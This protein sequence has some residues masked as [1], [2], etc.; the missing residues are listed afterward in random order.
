MNE[1]INFFVTLNNVPQINLVPLPTVTVYDAVT[2]S[3]VLT[4]TSTE[5]GG[6]FYKFTMPTLDP[7]INYLIVADA[8]STFPN[9][10][11]YY[12]GEINALNSLAA[13]TIWDY[14]ANNTFTAGSFGEMINNI[15]NTVASTD[16]T[17]GI[18]MALLNTL[19]KYAQNRAKVD[20]NTKTL[21]LYDDDQTTPIKIFKL[22]N[23][24]SVLDINTVFERVPQ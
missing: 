19:L 15:Q 18:S 17:T 11:R 6:G 4:G 3:I 23:N 12:T 8:G 5:V 20:P 2:N 14:P 9:S 1:N 10:E 22:Y 16:S 24:N 21:T 13:N 7:T